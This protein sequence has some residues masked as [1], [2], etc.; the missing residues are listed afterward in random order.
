MAHDKVLLCENCGIK[1][2]LNIK[3]SLRIYNAPEVLAFLQAHEYHHIEISTEEALD[4]QTKRY[5]E[6]N[7]NDAL[8]NE[9]YGFLKMYRKQ[10]DAFGS[11]K[12]E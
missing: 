7:P 12:E 10:L 5:Q 1:C 9:Y 3:T 4:C 11:Y 8:Y 6:C 2:D